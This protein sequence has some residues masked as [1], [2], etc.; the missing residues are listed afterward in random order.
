M[1]TVFARL[2]ELKSIS[3]Q[4]YPSSDEQCSYFADR[5]SK[6]R[7]LSAAELAVGFRLQARCGPEGSRRFRLPDSRTFGT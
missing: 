3:N 2:L 4:V 6:E 5:V 1:G 7:S